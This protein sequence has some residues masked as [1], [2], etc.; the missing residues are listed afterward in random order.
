MMVVTSVESVTRF[1]DRS[2]RREKGEK[3]R[4]GCGRAVDLRLCASRPSWKSNSVG[5]ERMPNLDPSFGSSSILTLPIVTPSGSCGATRSRYSQLLAARPAP[6]GPGVPHRTVPAA[7]VESKFS[8][9]SVTS[10]TVVPTQSR[11]KPLRGVALFLAIWRNS[12]SFAREFARRGGLIVGLGDDPFGDDHFLLGLEGNRLRV[13]R[14]Q[15]GW[16]WG[17][18]GTGT[19]YVPAKSMRTA[20][21]PECYVLDMRLNDLD[22]NEFGKADRAEVAS[23]RFPSWGPEFFP[24]KFLGR[25]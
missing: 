2:F 16:L 3:P 4:V 13:K 24:H 19:E 9:V 8:L 10:F 1:R 5:I 12:A 17:I 20:R 7:M 25:R 21:L 22:L 11:K 15:L 23:I 14:G 18:G 6:L